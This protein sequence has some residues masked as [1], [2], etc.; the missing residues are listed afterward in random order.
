MD[1]KFDVAIVGAGP[2][3]C[4]CAMQLGGKG[5]QVALLDKHDF[6]RDKVCG[7]A[8][9]SDVLNQFY[10]IDSS[11]ALQFKEFPDKKVSGG[12]RFYSPDHNRLDI[13]FDN[14]YGNENAGFISRRIDFDNF[15]FEQV[16]SLSDV[17]IFLNHEVHEVVRSEN[18]LELQT[19]IGNI[20]AKLV[21][22]ADGA[23]SAVKKLLLPDP[24][25]RDHH[26]AGLRQYF[27][28]VTGFHPDHHIELHFYKDLLPGYFWIFPLPGN[29]ANVGLGMLSSVVSK[30]KVNLK[31]KLSEII[32][33]HPNV[34]H[35]FAQARP[36]ES[37]KG[38][39]LPI[40]SKKR[41]LSGNRFLL[42]GDAAG[43]ID[44][45]VGEGIGNAI[46]SGRVAAAHVENALVKNRFDAD[47][48]LRYDNEI[49]SRMG[50][51]LK[52]GRSLQNIARHAGIFNFIVGKAN[53]NE[54]VRK[55]LTSML[56]NVDLRRE[57]V[58]PSFYA[59][60]IFA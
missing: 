12:V 37:S 24:I 27:E 42:L 25:E 31:K 15:L 48:N 56:G 60:L 55:L 13:S 54:S 21:L 17:T 34:K 58:K 52:L 46:R 43:L 16:K 40:G 45:F 38:F 47:F 49:Y 41:R 4:A 51:E 6:P 50:R 23:N 5:F 1:R 7:D 14:R 57:L 59:K 30:R 53:R 8:L 11:L 33:H 26:C 10:R 3:G 18:H 9:S 2:A 35:R 39:G 44:P 36:L 28:N 32:H 19:G 29:R 20:A 22:G